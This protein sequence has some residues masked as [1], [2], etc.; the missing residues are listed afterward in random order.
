MAVAVLVHGLYHLPEHFALVAK[1]LQAA[2]N[3]VVV[4]ELHRGSLKADTA[5][6]QA[7][8]DELEEPP[9]VLGHSYG[10]SVITGL[11]GARHLVYLA[12]FVPDVHE[13][14]ASLGGTS[15]QL[16]EAIV[17]EPDGFTRLQPNRATDVFYADCPEHL[18]AWAV[19]LLCAQAPG[20]GRG[21]PEYHSWKNTPSTY[22]VCMEDRAIAP[23]LQR[24]MAKRCEIVREW[25]TGH[26]PF[27]G[28]PQLVIELL[29]EL[30]GTPSAPP[31]ATDNAL[32]GTT[33]SRPTTRGKHPPAHAG[34]R[35]GPS[36]PP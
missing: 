23:D 27:I 11:R 35:A 21:V 9:V 30:L 25:R 32:H 14:A 1:G 15:P 22:V 20:C 12:A 10:G 16:R 19:N 28:Q 5:A 31:S 2:G 36:S 7:A 17:P 3:E 18:A 34:H 8:I 26:S 13:S 24:M 4:P 6:V 33:R 29:Q